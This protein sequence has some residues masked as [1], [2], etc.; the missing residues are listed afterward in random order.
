MVRLKSIGMPLE[1]VE[2]VELTG[3]GLAVILEFVEL[4]TGGAP[5]EFVSLVAAFTKAKNRKK[6]SILNLI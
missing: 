3:G 1:L 2:F 6:T 4:S 5:V